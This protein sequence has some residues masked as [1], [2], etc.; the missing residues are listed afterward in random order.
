VG[1]G[2]GIADTTGN[3]PFYANS[4]RLSGF[5]TLNDNNDLEVGLSGYTGIHDPYGR[6]RFWYGDVDFKYKF[7]P[8]SYT[9]LVVQGEYLTNFRKGRQD[10]SLTPF[11]D[12]AGNQ[13]ER[14]IATSGLYLFA[15]YRFQ[16]AYSV[17]ARYDWSASPYSA[18]DVARGIAVFAGFYPVEETLGLRLEYTNTWTTVSG[19]T[20]SVNGI[21]LQLLFSLGPHK[22]HPF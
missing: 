10:G 22:A 1:E 18:D 16:K 4:A 6:E 3:K 20:T 11:R 13:E 15:D 5:F 7:R 9:S 17:G 8:D 2:A 19:H 14:T 21:A 12:A